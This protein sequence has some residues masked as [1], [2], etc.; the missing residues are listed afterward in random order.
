MTPLV[1]RIVLHS[2]LGKTPAQI[3]AFCK[4]PV[5]K[6]YAILRRERP[7]RRR[8]PR[9]C[10]S[11]VPALVMGLAREGVKAARIASL[12]Q[13]SCAYVHRILAS[14]SAT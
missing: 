2:D 3:A 1:A 13:C 6:V 4:V 11:A 7:D 12:C 8:A 10:T 14:A 5:H 9:P